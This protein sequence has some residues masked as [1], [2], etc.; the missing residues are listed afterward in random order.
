M[1]ILDDQM[2]RT[3]AE[4]ALPAWGLS[5]PTI[6]LISRSENIVF[7]VDTNPASGPSKTY[8]LRIHRP[9]YHTLDALNSEQT[10]T[11]ILNE[12]GLSVPMPKKTSDGQGYV[13]VRVSGTE[14]PPEIRYVGMVEWFEG[15]PMSEIIDD[16]P[17]EATKID[18]FNQ[19]GRIAARLHNRTVDW[20]VPHTFYR[21]SFDQFGLMGDGML[22][23]APFWGRFWN[24]PQLSKEER[25]R[26]LPIRAAIYRRLANMQRNPQTYSL[27]HADLH[28][29]NV[30]IR[31]DEIHVIDFDDSGYGW[32]SYELAVSVYYFLGRPDFETIQA[33]VIAGYRAERNLDD[34]VIDEIIELIPLFLLIRCLALIGWTAARPELGKMERIPRLVAQAFEITRSRIYLW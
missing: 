23:Q 17:D 20:L 4:Q 29:G 28:P 12:R 16:L 27:I 31:G 30:L 22:G 8:V 34:Q 32:H 24:A 1:K 6:D 15:T 7:R 33:A 10:W 13:P 19:L 26:L 5:N 25:D 9:G 3:I 18:Y 14:M 21:H 11:T 2:A